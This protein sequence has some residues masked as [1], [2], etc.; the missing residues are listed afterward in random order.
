MVEIRLVTVSRE[1]GSLGS[2]IAERVATALAWNLVDRRLVYALAQRLGVTLEEAAARD[3]RV[4]GLAE[5]IA[6][7]LSV[8]LPEFVLGPTPLR[9]SD[10]H[11]KEITERILSRAVE[12]GPSVIVGH[13]SQT[14]F[15]DRADALHVRVHAPFTVRVG[16]V[17]ERLGLDPEAA[18]AHVKQV[19][20]DR[21]T[22]IK[23][24]YGRD[25]RDSGL[26]H[27]Q[28]NTGFFTTEHAAALILQCIR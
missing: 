2:A 3:E 16:R 22:Y 6:A 23:H 28:I 8:A 9:P 7:T 21:A 5:R 4:S 13:A 11:Y 17:Q 14:L 19:D 27:L 18:A 26:Y 20:S 1:I 24:H 10:R 15:A 25:W 12:A